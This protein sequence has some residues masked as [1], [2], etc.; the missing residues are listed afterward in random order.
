MNNKPELN[1]KLEIKPAGEESEMNTKFCE[2]INKNPFTLI[3]GVSING[4]NIYDG[5]DPIQRFNV[6][7]QYEN[8][9]SKQY[10]ETTK[11]SYRII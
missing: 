3:N 6:Y 1:F 4:I 8:Q 7:Q 10:D 5:E 2:M 9:K 11:F